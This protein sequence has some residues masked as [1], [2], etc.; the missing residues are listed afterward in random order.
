MKDTLKQSKLKH[1]YAN[2]NIYAT[3]LFESAHTKQYRQ[4]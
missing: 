1:T 3:L 4:T 2:A